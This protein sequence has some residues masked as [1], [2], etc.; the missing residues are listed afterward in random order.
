MARV[1]PQRHRKKNSI[2]RMEIC[3]VFG[4]KSGFMIISQSCVPGC[5]FIT[6]TIDHKEKYIG[7]EKENSSF[8]HNL[9]LTFCLTALNKFHTVL[10]SWGNKTVVR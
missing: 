6:V 3:S 9:R 5:L 4:P 2:L 7:R 1:G 8:I 10:S